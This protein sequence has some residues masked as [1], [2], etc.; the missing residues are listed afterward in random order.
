MQRAVSQ[1]GAKLIVIDPSRDVFP[2]WTDIWLK[3]E[4][5]S[6]GVLLGGL[7]RILV[8]KGLVARGKVEAGFIQSRRQYETEEV[9]RA[10]G[11]GKESLEKAAEVYGRA[12]RGIIIYGEGIVKMNDPS[13]VASLLRLADLTGNRVGDRLRV[14]SLKPAAN[15]RGG[16]ALGLAEREIKRDGF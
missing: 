15:S 13:L 5:G 1:G 12:D 7:A 6:E 11:I 10:T 9:S 14:I 2:L 4:E 16:W 3:P 8:D